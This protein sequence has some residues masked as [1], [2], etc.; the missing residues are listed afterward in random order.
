M[1]GKASENSRLTDG[2]IRRKI[3][4]YYT[5]KVKVF[6]IEILGGIQNPII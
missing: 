6:I 1:L 5:F 4:N 2:M 3:Y